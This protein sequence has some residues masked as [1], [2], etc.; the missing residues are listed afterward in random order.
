MIKHLRKAQFLIIQ[1][2]NTVE[3]NFH[4][5]KYRF[6]LDT[7]F[8]TLSQHIEQRQSIPL[9]PAS[10]FKESQ[11]WIVYLITNFF[12]CLKLEAITFQNQCQDLK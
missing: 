11:F 10:E 2:Q 8:V 3:E 1:A 9:Q 7:G 6:S 5:I 12:G 4:L